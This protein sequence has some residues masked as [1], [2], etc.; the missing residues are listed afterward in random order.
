MSAFG[1]GKEKLPVWMPSEGWTCTRAKSVGWTGECS[2]DAAQPY[3]RHLRLGVELLANLKESVVRVVIG[4]DDHVLQHLEVCGVELV[5][6]ADHN[7]R[8]VDIEQVCIG[9]CGIALR[10]RISSGG[11]TDPL[12]FVP[13]SSWTLAFELDLCQRTTAILRY[14]EAAG[15]AYMLRIAVFPMLMPYRSSSQNVSE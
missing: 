2:V 15:S 3:I 6:V 10:D 5:C 4:Q 8:V 9:E 13:S 1:Y 12:M 11:M 14:R 7:V